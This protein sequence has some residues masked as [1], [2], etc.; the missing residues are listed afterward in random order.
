MSLLFL[1]L[2]LLAEIVGTLGGF[3]SSV[4]FVPIANFYLP[5]QA[6]LGLTA[7]FHL[8]SNTSKVFL[9]RHG[10]NKRLLLYIGV[11]SVV[12]VVAG[13]F[14]SDVV[15]GHAL[16]WALGIFLVSMSSFFLL[17]PTIRI[18]THP[19]AAGAGG[20]LSGFT[21]GLL[22]TGGAIRGIAMAA[23][24]LEKSVFIASS[25]AIDLAVDASR[26]VVYVRNG[27]VRWEDMHYVPWLLAIGFIGTYI[28]KYFLR[29]VPQTYFKKLSLALILLIG[30][31]Q[32]FRLMYT[33]A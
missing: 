11:P 33:S 29:F 31:V 1:L 27:F 25:A 28:G 23:F 16:E 17:F 2:A 4:F 20:A 15:S 5:F 22:G 7:I 32:L 21:A 13:S 18:S 10:L 3:G 14:L 26:T 24:D 6:V 30:L 12:F 8:A 19:I 9:F